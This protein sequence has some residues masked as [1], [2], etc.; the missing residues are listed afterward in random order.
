[1]YKKEVL[2]TH[3]SERHKRESQDK[4]REKVIYVYTEKEKIAYVLFSLS[5]RFPL[6]N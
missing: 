2:K 6:T 3:T 5:D 4:R 1:M